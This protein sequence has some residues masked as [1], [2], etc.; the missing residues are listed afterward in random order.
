MQDSAN[1]YVL[2]YT[3]LLFET[4]L[5]MHFMHLGA[6]DEV[7]K[8]SIISRIREY[9]NIQKYTSKI[10][11]APGTIAAILGNDGNTRIRAAI[12]NA[13]ALQTYWEDNDCAYDINVKAMNPSTNIHLLV[14]GIMDEIDEICK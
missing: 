10:K 14:E 8:K 2:D 6:S 4:W 12:D 7:K 3:C 13:K 9:L 11:A 5:V 1:D